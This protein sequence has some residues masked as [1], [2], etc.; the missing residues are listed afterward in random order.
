[1]SNEP[2]PPPAETFAFDE[3]ARER[4]DRWEQ[5]LVL[6]EAG[7][8]MSDPSSSQD[9]RAMA[10][11]WGAP[12]GVASVPEMETIAEDHSVDPVL[13]SRVRAVLASSIVGSDGEKAAVLVQLSLS[14]ADDASVHIRTRL[15]LYFAAVDVLVR[16]GR[17]EDALDVLKRAAAAAKADESAPEW[18]LVAIDA[19]QLVIAARTGMDREQVARMADQIARVARQLDDTPSTVDVV[20][21]AS[22]VLMGLGA[23]KAAEA[24]Y[25]AV[26]EGAADNPAAR[27]PRY[28]ALLGMAEARLRLEGPDAAI[29]AQREAIAAVEP[30]G[31]TPMLGWARRGL[32]VQILATDRYSDAA[33][34]FARSAD[35]YDRIGLGIDAA[36]LRLEQSAALIQDDDAPGARA[37]ADAVAAAAEDMEEEKRL[38]LEL[39][40]HQVYAQLAVYDGELEV[41]AEHWLEVA[42]RA[43]ST[44]Q[45]PLEAELNAAQ[46]FAAAG[47][48]DEA[49]AQFGRA[50]LSAA[51][52]A[53]P[54]KATARVMRTH[55]ETLRQVGR[56]D[57]A[58]E[59]A[60][61]ASNLARAS[62]DEAQA[63]YLSVIAA[64]SLHGAGE[65]EA[66]LQLYRENLRAAED[67]EMP[68]LLGAVHA[69][70]AKLLRDLGRDDEAAAEEA[71]AAALGV[72]PGAP[73]A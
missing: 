47:D 72:A 62:G 53:D 73:S 42:D 39:R 25:E 46:L 27:A 58:A 56:S 37:V 28:Q 19:E 23:V 12:A 69:A 32:A 38:A 54:A 70:H 55:A 48:I 31:D 3:W 71:K 30:L 60:R 51:D 45:S 22:D 65:S 67:A 18:A 68:S 4:F 50:E 5:S 52:V 64:D 11:V 2:T 34:E 8:R 20:L 63:I 35:V 40:V 16:V 36:A 43:T 10:A 59:L 17:L 57:E 24:H 13:R 44:G 33:D 9:E 15:S 41:A 6:E 14:E 49:T 66:A 26:A 29:E 61:V 21:K 1:M 7:R